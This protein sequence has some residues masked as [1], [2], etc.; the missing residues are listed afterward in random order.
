MKILFFILSMLVLPAIASEPQNINQHDKIKESKKD[1]TTVFEEQC[2]KLAIQSKV[3]EKRL[4]VFMAEC[5]ASLSLSNIDEGEETISSPHQ[6][7][8]LP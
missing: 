5:I 1:K 2:L 6:T 3:P 4:S 7:K 8:K